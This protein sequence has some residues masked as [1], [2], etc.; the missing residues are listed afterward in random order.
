M[1]VGAVGPRRG[2][3]EDSAQVCIIFL[4]TNPKQAS[5]HIIVFCRIINNLIIVASHI[6][7]LRL[8]V[9]DAQQYTIFFKKMHNN[10]CYY[11]LQLFSHTNLPENISTVV[12][13]PHRLKDLENS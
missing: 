11:R 6:R 12:K 8:L 2:E 3:L 13:K 10:I 7:A 9:L 1:A 4:H 5:N